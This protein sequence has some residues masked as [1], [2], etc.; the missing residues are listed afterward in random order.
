MNCLS[1]YNMMWYIVSI[2]IFGRTYC[3]Y[4]RYCPRANTWVG[5]SWLEVRNTYCS[6]PRLKLSL[7]NYRD[8]FDLVRNQAVILCGIFSLDNCGSYWICEFHWHTHRTLCP[9]RS[10]NWLNIECRARA[11]HTTWNW[12]HRHQNVCRWPVLH[13]CQQ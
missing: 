2:R 4:T 11:R 9:Y 13:R 8:P 10:S 7:R 6:L 1:I 3:W 5:S 12:R